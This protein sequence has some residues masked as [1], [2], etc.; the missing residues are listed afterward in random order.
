LC[1]F[2]HH[3]Y[4]A[5]ACDAQN[6]TYKCLRTIN[7][8]ENSIYCEFDD[9]VK[10]V[11][12][13]DISNDPYQLHNL[14]EDGN[15]I[16]MAS[17]QRRL[18]EFM[19][20]WGDQC[21]FPPAH[22]SPLPKP[23]PPP[24][25]NETLVFEN[26]CANCGACEEK[27]LLRLEEQSAVNC[28]KFKIGINPSTQHGQIQAGSSLKCWN[29]EDARCEDGQTMYMHACG[30][31]ADAFT[32]DVHAKLIRSEKCPGMCASKAGGPPASPAIVLSSCNSSAAMGWAVS[33]V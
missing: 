26:L 9:D 8:T 21:F 22:P 31:K 1:H 5:A 2:S 20:C 30:G 23:P 6:N 4:F 32:F 16:K 29:I 14:H 27:G 17:L 13:Y 33:I 10:M 18:N 25:Y 11:E 24:G 19:E 12:Y 3:A 15:P 28:E 7:N